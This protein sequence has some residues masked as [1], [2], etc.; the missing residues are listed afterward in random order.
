MKLDSRRLPLAVAIALVSLVVAGLASDVLALTSEDEQIVAVLGLKAGS[1]VADVGAGDGEWSEKLARKVGD[2]GHV[3][4]TE[5][6]SSELDKIR[7]RVQDAGIPNVAAILGTQQDTGLPAA[8]CDAILVRMVYH[9]FTEPAR[10]RASL[11]AALR[12]GGVLAIID[13]KPHADWRKLEGVPERGGHGI[14]ED[15]LVREMTADGFEV[16]ARHSNWN[17]DNDRYCVVFRRAP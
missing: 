16:A 14:R 9:H 15:D 12:P 2:S 17:G 5:V 10:M 8:C 13:T 11:R 6:D 3:Y 1:T 7:K 4:A